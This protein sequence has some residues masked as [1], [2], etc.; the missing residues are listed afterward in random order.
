MQLAKPAFAAIAVASLSW[1][2]LFGQSTSNAPHARTFHVSGLIGYSGD[3]PAPAVEVTFKG[4]GIS[5]TIQSDDQGF[6]ETELPL[7][8]FTMIARKTFNRR[9]SLVYERPLF[10]VNS[11]VA[12]TLTVT[13][14][15][16]SSCDPV[17]GPSGVVPTAEEIRD[18]CGATD[19]YSIPSEDNTPFQLSIQYDS[20]HRADGKIEY[21]GEKIQNI[22][23]QVFVAYNLFGLKADHV[24]YDEHHRTLE[25]TGNVLVQHPNGKIQRSDSLRF[26]IQ[27]GEAS[28][29]H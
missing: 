2:S 24:V 19:L 7:G 13:F 10:R 9:S 12:V 11:P 16:A 15:T 26:R 18:Y 28:L 20:R 22:S 17:I 5:K 14:P 8:S 29:Q 25:A 1:A 23:A 6:Y 27:N 4:E 21:N 3:F